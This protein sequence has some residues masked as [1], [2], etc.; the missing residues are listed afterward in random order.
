[1]PIDMHSHYYGGLVED[2]RK[3]THRPYVAADELGR[4]VLHGMTG[5]APSCRRATRTFARG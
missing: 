5:R 4:D 3:R 2:L 1:M